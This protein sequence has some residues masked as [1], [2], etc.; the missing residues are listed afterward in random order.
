MWLLLLLGLFVGSEDLV[1]QKGY[2][3]PD[4]AFLADP[5][6]MAFSPDGRLYLLDRE[7]KRV[8]F[9]DAAGRF[10][11]AFGTEGQGPG[12]FLNPFQLQADNGAVYI[13]EDRQV[14]SVFSPKGEFVRRFHTTSARPRVF[15]PLKNDLF[16]LGFRSRDHRAMYMHFELRNGQGEPVQELMKEENKAFV[17]V[18]EGDNNVTIR[19]YMPEIDIQP[20]ENGTW[21][22]GFSQETTLR[23]IDASGKVL[24]THRFD[25]PQIESSERDREV[26]M[27]MSFP[28]PDGQR[29]G[30][31]DLPNI[32]VDFSQ[33]K[34]Y[35]TH[36]VLGKS[37][38][39]FVLSPIG[40]TDAVNTGHSYGT[41]VVC[42]RNSGKRV[43]KGF[44]RLPEDSRVFYKNNRILGVVLNDDDEF[45]IA[46]YTLKGLK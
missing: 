23:E 26:F 19:A 25:L 31:K 4:D 30:L 9:W 17:R 1:K 6:A 45:E 3:L 10:Q 7:Q 14:I 29:I 16:L 32:K 13:W 46:T 34:A 33:P 36:F 15:A 21:L 5:V 11:G 44:Y 42:D 40:S 2:L 22:A 43:G 27:S 38:I 39:A 28:G 20:T 18:G 37:R 24:K 8:F 35:Y 12:E 41:Y